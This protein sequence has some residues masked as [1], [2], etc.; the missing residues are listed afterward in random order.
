VEDW[1]LDRFVLALGRSGLAIRRL[2][3]A[4]SSLESMFF[5]LADPE[6][7]PTIVPESAHETV[8]AEP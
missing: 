6:A 3:L 8:S 5:A 1:A 7:D 4:V 2:E